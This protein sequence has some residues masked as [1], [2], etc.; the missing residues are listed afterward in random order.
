MGCLLGCWRVLG[1]FAD[2]FFIKY[3]QRTAFF[4]G[5]TS[6]DSQ[7]TASAGERSWGISLRTARFR[8]GTAEISLRTPGFGESS[9]A[10][11]E[12]TARSASPAQAFT[13]CSRRRQS[14]QIGENSADSRPRLP[15]CAIASRNLDF[16]R[17][18]D[19]SGWRQMARSSCASSLRVSAAWAGLI[20]NRPARPRWL[21]ARRDGRGSPGGRLARRG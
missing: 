5:R 1:W 12:R 6:S 10:L 8:V 13:V 16:L 17:F 20:A 18:S 7:R 21:S 9:T 14:A 2:S 15:T 19:L 11:G 3:S 4:G